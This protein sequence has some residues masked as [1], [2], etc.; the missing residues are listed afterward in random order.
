MIRFRPLQSSSFQAGMLRLALLAAVLLVLLPTLGR[1]AES[2]SQSDGLAGPG[3]YLGAICTVA[4]L[5]YLPLPS[6]GADTDTGT[7]PSD[8]PGA[9][10][11]YCPLLASLLL[12]ALWL[13]A[14]PPPRR[15][16]SGSPCGDDPH[17]QWRYPCGL[18]SRGPPRAF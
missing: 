15:T 3:V 8:L 12:L 4:G 2:R 18:G 13:L 10:C 6:G 1:L 5:R 16:S 7:T 9:D 14:F 17:A 11:D